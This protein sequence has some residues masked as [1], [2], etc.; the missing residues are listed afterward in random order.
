MK[1]Y[2]LEPTPEV[3][4]NVAKPKGS[5]TEGV[6]NILCMNTLRPGLSETATGHIFVSIMTFGVLNVSNNDCSNCRKKEKRKAKD[7]P[8]PGFE[9]T[10]F[11]TSESAP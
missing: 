5:L 3:R 2:A 10:P 11:G 7:L 9:P 4:R 6:E 1:D 8:A